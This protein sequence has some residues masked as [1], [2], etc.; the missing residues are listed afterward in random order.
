[1]TTIRFLT[2]LHISPSIRRDLVDRLVNAMNA[3]LTSGQATKAIDDRLESNGWWVSGRQM[4]GLLK[5]A[6]QRNAA[7]SAQEVR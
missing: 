2:R 3:G 1:M 5:S 6:R 4:S 7:A